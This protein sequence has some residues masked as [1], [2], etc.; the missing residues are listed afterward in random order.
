MHILHAL[1]SKQVSYYVYGSR[2]YRY[3][4]F[5]SIFYKILRAKFVSFDEFIEQFFRSK[6]YE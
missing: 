5:L 3:F 6:Q 2:T 1:K 4:I